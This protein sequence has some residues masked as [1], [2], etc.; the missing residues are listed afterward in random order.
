MDKESGESHGT[1]ILRQVNRRAKAG[2]VTAVAQY[3]DHIPESKACYDKKQA[4][5]E[6]HNQA[7]QAFGQH[8]V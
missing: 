7:I 2:M 1:E 3:I 5:G 4:E 8:L 6:N